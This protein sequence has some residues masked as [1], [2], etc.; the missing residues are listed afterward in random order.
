MSGRVVI[1]TGYLSIMSEVNHMRETMFCGLGYNSLLNNVSIS[2]YDESWVN[3]YGYVNL[4]IL[5]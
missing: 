2:S 1:Q 5:M 3:E 4:D